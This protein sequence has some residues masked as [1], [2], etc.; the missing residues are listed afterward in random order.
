MTDRLYE[1]PVRLNRFAHADLLYTPPTDFMFCRTLMAAPLMAIEFPA[2]CRQYPIV[3]VQG[4]DGTLGAQ[5]LLSVVADDNAFVNHLGQWTANYIPAAIRR[6]PFVLAEI[7]GNPSDFDVAIDEASP[8]FS[9]N[10][11]QALFSPQGEPEPILNAQIQFLQSVLQ[12]HRRTQQFARALGEAGLLTPRAVDIVRADQKRFGVR[13]ALVVDEAKLVALPGAT[14]HTFLTSGYLG[15]IYAHLLSL[16]CFLPLA[17]R[18]GQ[19][20]DADVMPWWAK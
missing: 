13:N 14:A 7:A 20:A 18:A 9:R 5:V 4:P 11:G 6:Y 17:N 1:R 10:H 2:A 15:W 8:C 3:F 12:E 16:Q 19:T